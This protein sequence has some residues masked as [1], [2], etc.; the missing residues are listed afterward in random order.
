MRRSGDPDGSGVEG[1]MDTSD[2]IDLMKIVLSVEG[3]MSLVTRQTTY[4]EI[5]SG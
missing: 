3:V 2:S 4:Q 1:G 5:S